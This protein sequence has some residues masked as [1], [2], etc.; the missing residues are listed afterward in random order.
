MAAR[1][2]YIETVTA[3]LS[4]DEGAVCGDATAC[5]RETGAT[6]LLLAD[7]L[8]HGIRANVA[9]TLCLAR[10]E[11]LLKSGYSAQ[12]A[13]ASVAATMEA[14]RGTDE[15][16]AVFGVLRVLNSGEATLLGYDLPGVVLMGDG[17]AAVLPVRP[18]A[19]GAAT[20]MESTCRLM[21]GEGLLMVS[22]GV[23]QAG[24]GQGL[25]DGW[26]LEG[27]ASAADQYLAGNRPHAGLPDFLLGH[28]ERLCRGEPGDD[29]TVLMAI[30]RW[31][32]TLTIL[33]GPPSDEAQD[34]KVV[35][36]FLAEDGR[37]VVCGGTTA[38]IVARQMG[39][40][41]MTEAEPVSLVAP[42]R[43]YIEGID[44]VAEG[45]VTLNQVYNVL[46][47]DPE[48]FDEI[49]V[50]TDLVELLRSADRVNVIV[51]RASNA[52]DTHIAFR[53]QGL[54]SR[55]SI[56]PLLVKKLEAAGKLVV[57]EPV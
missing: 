34:R 37:K 25:R 19:L 49:S 27:V 48:Q 53:Q 29:A 31:G 24:L 56:I 43:Q 41:L 51:G 4:R 44:L 52:A 30:C 57:V 11:G 13:V 18:I 45:A 6:T 3:S 23:T 20:V 54:L 26:T 47:S 9:A 35:E 40:L 8:G 12:H 38:Q 32:R 33:T 36:R 17:H 21:P 22:D 39:R 5:F 46:D 1:H 15:P 14:C 28:A 50:V 10:L 2:L 55:A 16:Y 7:G 42:P